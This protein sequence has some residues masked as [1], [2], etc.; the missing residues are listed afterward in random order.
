MAI[1]S[2]VDFRAA[3]STIMNEW[4]ERH[5][6]EYDCKVIDLMLAHVPKEKIES[7][8]NRCLP[9]VTA[10]TRADLGLHVERRPA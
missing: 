1:M 10:G 9:A 5:G 7:A 2:L 3:F 6:K 4:V 8:Y